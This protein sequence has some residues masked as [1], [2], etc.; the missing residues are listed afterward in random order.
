M[1]RAGAIT[2]YIALLFLS[3]V[4]VTFLVRITIWLT[5]ETLQVC[6]SG[7]MTV[8][9]RSGRLGGIAVEVPLFFL[10]MLFAFVFQATRYPVT[11]VM[12]NKSQVT[13]LHFNIYK[14]YLVLF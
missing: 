7:L 3:L 6:Y 8:A 13:T 10:S 14:L 5:F 12:V 9:V 2:C 4:R 11:Y 1:S